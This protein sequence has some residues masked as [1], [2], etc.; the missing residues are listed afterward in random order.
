MFRGWYPRFELFFLHNKGVV[1]HSVTKN[2]F[3]S[4]I[5]FE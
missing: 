4:E 2:P 5:V 1:S 3:A